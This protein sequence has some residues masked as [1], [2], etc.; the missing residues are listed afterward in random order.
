[1]RRLRVIW[2][3]THGHTFSFRFFFLLF[4][5]SDAVLQETYPFFD[6]CPIL[7]QLWIQRRSGQQLHDSTQGGHSCLSQFHESFLIRLSNKRIT[8]AV[9]SI[10]FYLP[11]LTDFPVQSLH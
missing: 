3:I 11:G 5:K 6:L 9:T 7:I 2:R 4:H 1:M 10:A 8:V